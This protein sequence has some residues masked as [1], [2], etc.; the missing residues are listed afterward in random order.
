MCGDPVSTMTDLPPQPSSCHSAVSYSCTEAT[1]VGQPVDSWHN[2]LDSTYC[3]CVWTMDWTCFEF[4]KPPE[5]QAGYPQP[6]QAFQ[7][8]AML[9]ASRW[10][11]DILFRSF[12]NDERWPSSQWTCNDSLQSFLISCQVRSCEIGCCWP[13]SDARY[14]Q[15]A[16]YAPYNAY[17]ATP[18]QSGT[19]VL[20]WRITLIYRWSTDTLQ[21]IQDQDRSSSVITIWTDKIIVMII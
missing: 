19:D 10:K 16:P 9:L 17:A 20:W 11:R 4:A 15:Q 5:G 8:Q 6:V 1:V 21:M 13:N 18:D 14:G 3:L 12:W 7:G 2:Q